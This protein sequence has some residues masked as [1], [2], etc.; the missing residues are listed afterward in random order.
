M[1]AS[2][3]LPRNVDRAIAAAKP[4]RAA[5]LSELRAQRIAI[6]AI[7]VVSLGLHGH[8]IGVHTAVAG[9]RI[10]IGVEIRRQAKRDRSVAR[11]DIPISLQ[12][13]A[14]E[15]LETNGAVAGPDLDGV[16]ATG[17]LDRTVARIGLD[18]ASGI[19]HR[20]RTI[21]RTGLQAALDTTGSN[22]AVTAAESNRAGQLVGIDRPIAS[23]RIHGHLARRRHNQAH[24]G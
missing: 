12:R 13:A 21:T 6:P 11:I 2:A 7:V 19:G 22:A 1:H 20:D 16:E 10:E 9:M 3:L 18:T 5:A 15:R 8:A 17:Q 4:Q 23:T 24:R 14:V